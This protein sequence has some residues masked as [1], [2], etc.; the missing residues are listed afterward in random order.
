MNLVSKR[1]SEIKL[2]MHEIIS[3]YACSQDVFFP[4]Y[5]TAQL[6]V[7]VAFSVSFVRAGEGTRIQKVSNAM[8]VVRETDFPIL[9]RYTEG[10]QG[11]QD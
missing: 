2:G 8:L 4:F 10:T 11:T 1:K 9:K 3:K 7:F 5:D 6:Y